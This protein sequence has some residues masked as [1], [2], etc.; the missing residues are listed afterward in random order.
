[1]VTAV[2]ACVWLLLKFLV[3]M[4]L[5]CSLCLPTAYIE[6]EYISN[7][8]KAE[9]EIRAETIDRTYCVAGRHGFPKGCNDGN[10]YE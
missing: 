1:M 4:G 8:N 7:G 9:G 5:S 10:E 2:T 3:N 6:S